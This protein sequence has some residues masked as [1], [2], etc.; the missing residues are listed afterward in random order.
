MTTITEIV[1]GKVTNNGI[2]DK[3]IPDYNV[4]Y[5]VYPL[6]CPV[7]TVVTPKGELASEKGTQW[8]NT[9]DFTQM[10][11]DIFDYKTPFYNPSSLLVQQLG[12]GAQ[13]VIGVRRVS[14]NNEL[15]RVA[16]SAFV[17]KFT[18]VDYERDTSGQ[19]KRDKNGERIPTGKT[20][21]GI[22]VVVRPDPMA[23]TVGYGELVH[24]TIPGSTDAGD[25]PGTDYGNLGI[26]ESGQMRAA[27]VGDLV[28]E[29]DT[30]VYPLFELPAGVGDAYNA[31]GLNMGVANNPTNWR[32]IA[33][34]V[35][36]TAVFPYDLKMFTDL[37]GGTRR[38][39]KT[40]EKR[41]NAKFTLFDTELNNT[42]YSLKQAVGSFTNTNGNRKVIPRPM[43]FKEAYV[44]AS[45]IEALAQ[46]MYV[47][48]KPVNDSLV[49]VGQ[50]D[51]RQMNPLTCT[52]HNGAP[53]Y[54][55]STD[56]TALWDLSAAVKAEGGISPFKTKE[57]K[58][59]EG[60][61]TV[62][63]I[64]PF[65]LLKDVVQPITAE[66][67]W[68]TVNKLMV[69]DLTEYVGGIETK[70]YT[71]NRQSVFWDVGYVKEVKDLAAQLLGTRKDI[72]VFADAT[73]WAP[74]KGN[75]LGEV[76]SRFASLT[77]G[78]RL[79]PESEKWGT[80]TVRASVN[81]IEAKLTNET[82]G[83]YFSG[84]LDLA[85]FFARF[86]GNSDGTVI[87]ANSPDH[88]DNRILTTM[89]TPNIEF[90]EDEVAAD[91]FANGGITLRPYD[92]EQ[93]FRPALI[94]VY[95]N[96]DSVLKDTVTA[97]LCVCIHKILQDEWNVVCGDTT[98]PASSYTSLVKDGA[99]RK[100]RDRL[101][102]IVRNIVVET[103]YDEGQRGNRGVMNAIAHA[104]FNKGK[105][106]M[107]LDLF[108]YNEQDQA[109]A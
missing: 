44:Y 67:A 11:G 57:G 13:S 93:L 61:P 2:N 98:I 27:L 36:A 99:E 17:Q 34:F 100:C 54:A 96:E 3:S 52:N 71:R 97:F 30:E 40:I 21:E 14:A 66:Q 9:A 39:A 87:A 75:N 86:A 10:F 60:V 65:N 43:P 94:T 81:L 51:Y 35:K 69:N 53:Y 88:G 49:E 37:V 23:K 91:D 78:L 5:P 28:A 105:Y 7:I 1:A 16:M 84:N 59:L 85:Y 103:S 56:N 89:H 25:L 32:S 19:F 33:D 68:S 72:F 108:A 109:A 73:V 70:N 48:E 26:P 101:G 90:E 104:W 46:L 82:T 38:Y 55:I 74:G 24:R 83:D 79:T 63:L 20:F 64:D 58:Y 22:N 31:S 12:R 41:E 4:I 92:V 77:A 47:V 45:E 107:N 8:I 18:V 15:A 106:M 6:H 62:T 29:R 102:G 80:P 50:A 42:K 95:N 76:Y